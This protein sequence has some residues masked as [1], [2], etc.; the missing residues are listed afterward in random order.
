MVSSVSQLQDRLTSD[1][2][3]LI[4]EGPGPSPASYV[5]IGFDGLMEPVN[6]GG[7]GVGAFVLR[8]NGMVMR[9]VAVLA[10]QPGDP[11]ASNNVAEY[12]GVIAA[13]E[14]LTSIGFHGKAVIMG[15]SQ[16]VIYQLIG[17]YQVHSLNL[18]PLHSKAHSLMRNL[19]N[20]GASISIRWVPREENMDADSVTREG[21]V[22]FLKNFRGNASIGHAVRPPP[23][24]KA[25]KNMKVISCGLVDKRGE[26]LFGVPSSV[27]NEVYEVDISAL[28]CTCQYFTKRHRPCKHITLVIDCLLDMNMRI[29]GDF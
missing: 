9:R 29:E 11:N 12:T 20:E 13:L 26:N 21:F 8:E 18:L 3:V 5:T 23:G 2:T 22:T 25:E 10:G 4:K 14:Y 19:K 28:T 7:I 16:V 6:P 17:T 1:G 24:R 27:S 15:D